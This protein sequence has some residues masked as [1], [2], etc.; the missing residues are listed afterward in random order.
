M[1]NLIENKDLVILSSDKGSCVASLK[2]SDYDEKLQS[3]INEGITNGIYT[4]NAGSLLLW[5]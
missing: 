5:S 4:P 1:K 3:M 2:R